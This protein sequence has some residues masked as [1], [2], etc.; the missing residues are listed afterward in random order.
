LI[1]LH[2]YGYLQRY[3]PNPCYIMLR[4]EDAVMQAVS[5]YR[6]A[7]QKTWSVS[8]EKRAHA[9]YNREAIGHYYELIA[10]DARRWSHYFSVEGITPFYITY[11]NLLADSPGCLNHLMQHLGLGENF[12][13]DARQSRFSIQRDETNRE[14]AEK[15]MRETGISPRKY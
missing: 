1:F 11:E 6:A 4:R 2:R 7:Y 5:W 14:W 3:F 12:T 9:V 10:D 8:H 13:V 15:F